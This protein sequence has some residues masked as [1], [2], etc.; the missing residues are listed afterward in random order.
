MRPTQTLDW[1]VDGERHFATAM[2]RL[3]DEELSGP[4]LL[5]DWTRAHVLG[6][7]ARNADAL[8][9]LLTWARTGEKTPMYPSEE[10]RDA[11]I[12][13]AAAL[14][15][16]KLRAEVLEATGRLAAAV[17]ELPDDAWGAEVRTN[18]DRAV[19][20]EAV[21]WMRCREVFVHAVDLAA[22]VTFADV[23][24]EVQAALIDDVFAMWQR[25]DVVPDVVLFAGEREW[26]SG[27]LGVAGP[28]PAV[29]AW[30]T[31]RSKGE[32]LTADGPLPHL[33][34]WL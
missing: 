17:R 14:P 23:P 30:L 15:P 21:P 5:P 10:A 28:L 7:A 1:W 8:V 27:S 6:H 19:L 16:Q 9:N 3:T 2:G 25:R 33:P 20:A 13:E 11:G 29:T 22:G 12:A 26:G 18:S 24:E 34:A 4:S 31:G 32:E